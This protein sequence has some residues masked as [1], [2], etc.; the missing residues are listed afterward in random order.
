MGDVDNGEAVGRGSM[1]TTYLPLNCAI[2][3]KL[4]LKKMALKTNNKDLI[5]KAGGTRM[6]LMRKYVRVGKWPAE[7]NTATLS[8]ASHLTV[9]WGSM[10]QQLYL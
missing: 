2:T 9:Q 6:S 1:D 5:S 8:G 10:V 4:L 7:V 3:L